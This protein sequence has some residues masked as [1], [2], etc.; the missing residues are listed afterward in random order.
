MSPRPGGSNNSNNNNPF[1]HS[2]P[3]L[4][5]QGVVGG[6]ALVSMAWLQAPAQAVPLQPQ[7]WH[8]NGALYALYQPVHIPNAVILQQNTTEHSFR[9]SR[10]DDPTITENIDVQ[11]NWYTLFSRISK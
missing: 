7:N 4:P 5:P 9:L 10:T 2:Y 3:R 6:I 1:P 11:L 8:N